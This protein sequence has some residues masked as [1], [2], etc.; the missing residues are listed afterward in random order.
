MKKHVGVIAAIAMLLLAA[1]APL[2]AQTEKEKAV[3]EVL[4]QMIDADLKDDAAELDRTL[5]PDYVIVRDNGVVR[6]RAETLEGIKS[7]A[8]KFTAFDLSD[9]QVRLYGDTAVVTFHAD[10][11][12][13]RAGKDM[14][15]QF[16]EVRVFV[17]HGGP[18]KA[19]LAQRTRI[20][21][22]R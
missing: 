9:V 21:E 18:W 11:H 12:G 16:R 17:N 3:R 13:S 7:R 20:G 4:R 1:A 5:A 19:V 22:S 10:I 8:T 2:T 14:S 15:G 6:S